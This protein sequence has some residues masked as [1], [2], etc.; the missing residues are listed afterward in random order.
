[1]PSRG[2]YYEEKLSRV[3]T[4]SKEVLVERSYWRS[5]IKDR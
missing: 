5:E 2:E 4:E 1:M 3:R